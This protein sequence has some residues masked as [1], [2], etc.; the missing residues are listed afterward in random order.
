MLDNNNEDT[1][2]ELYYNAVI[3]DEKVKNKI[4][5]NITTDISEFQEDDEVIDDETSF[6]IGTVEMT[7][8][9]AVGNEM[10]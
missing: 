2:I 9:D 5:K 8:N 6:A 10:T 1:E 7:T 4:D 3:Y